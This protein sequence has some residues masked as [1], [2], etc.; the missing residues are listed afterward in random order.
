MATIHLTLRS[1]RHTLGAALVA[2]ALAGCPLNHSSTMAVSS[3]ASAST[4]SSASAGAT[5]ADGERA[6]SEPTS[7]SARSRIVR[8]QL[9]ALHGLTPDQAK[10]QLKKYGHDGE[11]RLGVVTDMGG[12]ET[13][14]E[15]CGID[16]VCETSG[17]S[18]IS[19]HDDIT[20]YLNPVLTIAPPP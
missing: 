16:K 8:S 1:A 13:F 19:I 2:L 14:V 12:G 20:L 9:E 6:A 17:S 15:A 18:G 3:S 11:V 7:G 10:A 4:S 5:R